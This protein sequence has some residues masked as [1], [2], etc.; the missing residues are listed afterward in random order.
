MYFLRQ[1]QCRIVVINIYKWNI[2]ISQTLG[3]WSLGYIFNPSRR[4]MIFFFKSPSN[5]STSGVDLMLLHHHKRCLVIYFYSPHL[6]YCS[7]PHPTL[8]PKKHIDPECNGVAL[9]CR[10]PSRWCSLCVWRA[11][12]NG[13]H[14]HSSAALGWWWTSVIRVINKTVLYLRIWV[15]FWRLLLCMGACVC[16]YG[17]NFIN[18]L[19]YCSFLGIK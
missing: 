4:K 18:M 11:E 12:K 14:D 1:N 15:A 10:Q 16:V 3:N 9:S 8:S 13:K 17:A 2:Y 5:V 6:H 19:L 7:P